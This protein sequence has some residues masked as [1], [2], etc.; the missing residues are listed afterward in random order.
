MMMQVIILSYWFQKN[1]GGGQMLRYLK[2]RFV[3]YSLLTFFILAPI[4]AKGMDLWRAIPITGRTGPLLSLKAIG[5]PANVSWGSQRFEAYL[6]FQGSKNSKFF[7]IGIICNNL[8]KEIPEE[9]LS[10]FQG[11]NL[12]DRAG[13]NYFSISLKK[14]DQVTIYETRLIEGISAD[15]FPA[16]IRSGSG[17][18]FLAD[19]ESNP[20]LTKIDQGKSLKL[21]KMLSEGVD[22]GRVIIDEGAFSKQIVVEFG[23]SGA[24]PLAKDFMSFI[25]IK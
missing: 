22:G 5:V 23:G 21:L 8:I 25:S 14:G 17:G 4:P 18:K 20:S 1:N 2:M 12:A 10:D 13:K 24:A 16:E 19:L 7:F 3:S 9:L 11:P 6:F 15:F